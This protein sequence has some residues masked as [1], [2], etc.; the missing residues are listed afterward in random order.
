MQLPASGGAA[1]LTLSC[2]EGR[3]CGGATASGATAA[4][5]RAAT[6]TCVDASPS[7]PP[8]GAASPSGRRCGSLL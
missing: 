3:Y 8:A 7:V 5:A 6:G 4:A 1:P 2:S